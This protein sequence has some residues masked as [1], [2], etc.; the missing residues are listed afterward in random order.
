LLGAA[1][2]VAFVW[3]AAQ[4]RLWRDAW[5]LLPTSSAQVA[6]IVVAGATVVAAMELGLRTQRARRA[7]PFAVIAAAVFVAALHH[8]EQQRRDATYDYPGVVRHAAE[9]RAPGERLTTLGIPALPVAFYLG[10][11]VTELSADGGADGGWARP[12]TVVMIADSPALAGRVAAI[13]VAGHASL[14]RQQVVIGRVSGSPAPPSPV[15]TSAPPARR[16]ARMSTELRHI[17]FEVLCVMIAI[18]AVVGRAYALR[19]GRTA[20]VYAAEAVIILALASFPANAWVF[21]AGGATAV[22]CVYLRWRRPV[23]AGDAHV[24]I[25]VLLMVALP[26]D[27]LEDVLQGDPV[28]VDPVWGVSAVL[29]I[30]L[31]TWRRL[32]LAAA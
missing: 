27:V 22:S 10:E 20:V 3:S 13:D 21:M 32:R 26:L 9:L 8:A 24:W 6:T 15:V 12:G 25:A 4:G 1:A 18:A 17:A 28:T 23:L 2:A 19:H 31:L 14:G 5:A 7:I 16:A 29:G 11:P 30:A